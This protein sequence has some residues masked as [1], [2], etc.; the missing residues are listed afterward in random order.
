M[1]TIILGM[2]GIASELGRA[3]QASRLLGVVEKEFEGCIKPL[4]IW[5]QDEFDGIASGVCHRLDDSTFNSTWS[6]V[7]ELTLEQALTEARQVTP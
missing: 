6:A 1:L 7:R 3:N 4:D 5:D 2:A